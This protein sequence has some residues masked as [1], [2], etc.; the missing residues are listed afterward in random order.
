MKLSSEARSEN[1][2]EKNVN[3]FFEFRY[4]IPTT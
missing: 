2:S 1:E 4:R 3:N